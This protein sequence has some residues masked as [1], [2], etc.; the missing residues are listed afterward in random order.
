MSMGSALSLAALYHLWRPGRSR[1]SLDSAAIIASIYGV[2]Q[3]SAGLYPGTV[4]G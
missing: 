4:T 3:L 2:T 1:A